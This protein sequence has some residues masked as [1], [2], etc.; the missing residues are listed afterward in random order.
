MSASCGSHDSK[1]RLPVLGTQQAQADIP[2]R[3]N[4][5]HTEKAERHERIAKMD[6]MVSAR[7]VKCLH[8]AQQNNVNST[9]VSIFLR[10][11]S[12]NLS[13]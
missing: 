1:I 7:E 5:L 4:V 8:S 9:Y 10:F 11:L 12:H 3:V 6:I 13:K 2:V